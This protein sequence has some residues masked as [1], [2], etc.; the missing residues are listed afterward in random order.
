MN[1]RFCHHPLK[2]ELVDLG[3]SPLANSFLKPVQLIEPEEFFPLKPYVCEECLLVQLPEHKRAAEI[4]HDDYAYFSSYSKSW[5]E[6]ARR[7]AE[8]APARLNLRPDANI[9]EIGSNDGYLLQNFLN[10]DFNVVGIEPSKNVASVA[11]SK[12]IRTVE[13]FFGSRLARVLK[14]EPLQADLLI[15]NNVLAQVPDLNDFVKGLGIMLKEGGVLTM[16]FPH[17][18]K[19]VELNQFD[20]IYHE[21]YSYFSFH[22]AVRIFST[23]GLRIFDVEEIPVH[24][25]SLR[26]YARHSYM[27]DEQIDPSVAKLLEKEKDHGL[28]DMAFYLPFQRRTE[29]VRHKLLRFLFGLREEGKRIVGYG[30]AAKGNTLLNYCGIGPDLLPFVVDRSRQKQGRFTPGSH[31]PVKEERALRGYLPDFVLILAWNIREEIMCQLHYISEWGGRFVVAFPEMHVCGAAGVRDAA[32]SNSALRQSETCGSART[33]CSRIPLR[34]ESKHVAECGSI[35]M[36][37]PPN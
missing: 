26:I 8:M 25:G 21:H 12:G 32:E 23:H 19:L 14:Q 16:E 35:S 2:Q 24:G 20:T 7:Y 11:Q 31:I 37:L 27:A 17:L 1:C 18:M 33:K 29:K 30:A 13:R 6:H 15:G 22:T 3:S 5:V 10:K 28:T 36:V 34:S 4:F 9:V